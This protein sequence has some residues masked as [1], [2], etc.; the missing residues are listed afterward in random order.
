MNIK[1]LK[2]SFRQRLLS[3]AVRLALGGVAA[4]SGVVSAQVYISPFIAAGSQSTGD[5]GSAAPNLWF[6]VNNNQSM[7]YVP[8]EDSSN[9]SMTFIPSHTYEIPYRLD[10]E[11]FPDPPTDPKQAYATPFYNY[12]QNGID[13]VSG[14]NQGL[15]DEYDLNKCYGTPATGWTAEQKKNCRIWQTYYNTRGNAVKSILSIVLTENKDL[16]KDT[17][18]GYIS[19]FPDANLPGN[20][21]GRGDRTV[22]VLP[23]AKENNYQTFMRWLF[24]LGRQSDGEAYMQRVAETVNKITNKAKVNSKDNPFIKDPEQ[25]F[26]ATTNPLLACRRN[27][28]LIFSDGEWAS[29]DFD[30]SV[31]NRFQ[32]NSTETKRTFPDGVEYNPIVPY[33]RNITSDSTSQRTLAD[34]AFNAWAKDMDGDSNNNQY[35]GRNNAVPPYFPKVDGVVQEHNGSPYWHPYNDPAEW[36][37]INTHTIGFDLKVNDDEEIARTAPPRKDADG[38]Y[39]T[40]TD[41]PGIRDN[42][43]TDS[44]RWKFE[45]IG[46]EID[47]NDAHKDMASAALAGRGR[48]Y[49][50][51]SAKELKEAITDILGM[52]NEQVVKPGVRGSAGALASIQSDGNSFYS[53]RYDADSFTGEVVRRNLFSGKESEKNDCFKAETL[54]SLPSSANLYGRVCDKSIEWNA[55]KEL[56]DD[57]GD[58]FAQR[59][60][61][62]A[63]RENDK[64]VG[65]TFTVGNLTGEQKTRI[66]GGSFPT[67]FNG[68]SDDDERFAKLVNYLRG[69][70]E[71]EDANVFHSRD[72]TFE[73]GTTGRNILGAIMRSSPI[74]SGIPRVSDLHS[75]KQST[76]Y[77]DFVKRYL[78]KDDGTSLCTGSCS[79]PIA[80]DDVNIIY[81]GA[82][83]GMLHAFRASDGKEVFSY[84]PDAVYKNLAQLTEDRKH[85][86]FVDGNIG[87]VVIDGENKK[88]TKFLTGSMGGGAKGIYAL[89]VTNPTASGTNA[90]DIVKWE[91]TDK[92]SGNIGNIIAKPATVQLNDGTWAVVVGNGYNSSNNK[93]A[94]I[95]INALTG[96]LIQE[97]I[98]DNSYT[99]NNLPN[100]LAPAYFQVFPGKESSK[101]NGIDRAYAGDLQGNMWVFDFSEANK[102]GGVTVAGK[103]NT[104]V[105]PLFVAQY[106]DGSKIVKQPI[107]VAPLVRQHPTKYGNMVHFGTGA[108]FDENDLSSNIKNSIYAIWDDWLESGIANGSGLPSPRTGRLVELSHLKELEFDELNGE[109]L[110]LASS[111]SKK[112]IGRTLKK[113]DKIKW[114]TRGLDFTDKKRGWYIDLP[115]GERAWQ[116]PYYTFGAKNT[117]AV[118]YD[119]VNY[120]PAAVGSSGGSAAVDCSSG[121]SGAVSWKM[122]FN[123]D[124][125]SK[126]LPY[127]GTIDTDGDSNITEA[128][129]VSK[130]AGVASLTGMSNEGVVFSDNSMSTFSPQE[131][132]KGVIVNGSNVCNF[133]T[134][135]HE[136]DGGKFKSKQICR[137]SHAGTWVELR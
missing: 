115:V 103:S 126:K 40:T 77:I 25:D 121:A 53:T 36:Q 47:K 111:T 51:K 20:E 136:N 50:A 76:E 27:H 65:Q 55:A 109:E 91:F 58:N 39:T 17:R 118:G 133:I 57:Y 89:D 49:N 92:D 80:K 54:S 63:K 9:T 37:H 41:N 98:L 30:G 122:A 1:I 33:K 43:F 114:A 117:E 21:G 97:I 95:I 130:G 70:K 46:S 15:T 87:V 110:S 7:E 116:S 24:G 134:Q 74:V 101:T 67:T 131:E 45:N 94:L 135:T 124:D 128:D 14:E 90:E 3:Q 106:T 4:F 85:I 83:D 73:D 107:T 60:V 123:I 71:Q 19:A 132:T 137:S 56:V 11:R 23:L 16:F 44:W 68:F 35:T 81:V 102:N 129:M 31:Y 108:L 18:V 48:F 88:W 52:I 28:L 6:F 62:T 82:N 66:K 12:L 78:Y 84:V 22:P 64:F 100:G 38:N 61:L 75:D 69:D 120:K 34:I 99:D 112:V 93:A 26:N 2:L 105:K 5:S 13:Y 119:T 79:N 29:E 127:Y 32:V 72:T 10:G 104:E 59:K 42:Y 113:S 86:S 8:S 96:K 125:G